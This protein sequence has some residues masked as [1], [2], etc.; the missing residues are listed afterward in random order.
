MGVYNT[1]NV[2]LDKIHVLTDVDPDHLFDE[3]SAGEDAYNRIEM[4]K[5]EKFCKQ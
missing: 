2:E 5:K 4:D 3:F 1:L